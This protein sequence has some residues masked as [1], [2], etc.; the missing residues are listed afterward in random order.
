MTAVTASL[1]VRFAQPR[2]TMK[3]SPGAA[4]SFLHTIKC[5]VLPV[6]PRYDG[7]WSRELPVEARTRQP[8]RTLSLNFS[9]PLLGGPPTCAEIWAALPATSNAPAHLTDAVADKQAG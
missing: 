8:V 4:V 1:F 7:I 5:I 6:L 3:A 2:H 9:I